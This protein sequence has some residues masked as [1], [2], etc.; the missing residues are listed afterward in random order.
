MAEEW[1]FHHYLLSTYY[2]YALVESLGR[3]R[4]AAY[5]LAIEIVNIT[6]YPLA[7]LN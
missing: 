2:I 6:V 7:Y 5:K 3:Y 4:V 1:L